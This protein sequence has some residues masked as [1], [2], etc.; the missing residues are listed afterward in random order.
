MQCVFMPATQYMPMSNEVIAAHVH[1]QVSSLWMCLQGQ[2]VVC[3]KPKNACAT[4]ALRLVHH[5]WP[6]LLAQQ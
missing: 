2:K 1:Q 6:G 4:V 3:K 5:H